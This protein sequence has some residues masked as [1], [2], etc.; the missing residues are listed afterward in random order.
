[1]KCEDC[2]MWGKPIEDAY[3]TQ[4]RLCEHPN[5][6]DMCHPQVGDCEIVTIANFGCVLFAPAVLQEQVD[7]PCR[8]LLSVLPP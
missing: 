3:P 6:M 8:P 2:R 7:C 1:M 5:L 4:A